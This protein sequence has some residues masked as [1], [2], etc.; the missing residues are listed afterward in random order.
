MRPG[1]VASEV[2]RRNNVR[3]SGDS[4]ARPI[5]F[6]HGFGCS[7]DVWRDVVPAFESDHRVITY[8]LV[9]AGGSDVAA[10][11]RAKY[12]TL[13]GYATDLL[14]ILDD[15][16]LH[17]VVFVGHSVSAMIGVLAANRAPERFGLLVL[18][19]PSPRYTNTDDYVG[20]FEPEDI[21]GLL[22][23]LD[24]NYL[25]WSATMAPVIAGNPDR[26][27]VGELLTQSF[28]AVQPDIARHFAR[29][30]FLSDNRDDLGH[31]SVPTLILQCSEDAIAPDAVGDFVHRSIPGSEFVALQ[32]TG[33]TPNLSAP[34]ELSAVI[35]SHL[36]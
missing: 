36:A 25:G 24:S 20:G 16:D 35:R 23:A 32:A 13:D 9:G 5:V 31:V 18:V 10:Y 12:D 26:P 17:D 6:S 4:A 19:G 30:T 11:D 21:Q 1:D 15:L 28:C 29:V 22:D 34:D 3:D 33:H 8:D 14:E 2:L 27:E 7:Q